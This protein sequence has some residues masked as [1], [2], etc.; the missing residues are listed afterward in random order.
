LLPQYS[1]VIIDEAHERKVNIDLLIG[2]LSRV[3]IARA[4]L[5]KPLRLVIMSA[6]LRLDD[7]LNNKLVFP[8]AINV[9]KIQAR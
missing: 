8:R 2:V 9:I 7:F 1:V 3:V 6:T 4:K 5:D